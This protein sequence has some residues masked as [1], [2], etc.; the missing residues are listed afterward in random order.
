MSHSPPPRPQASAKRL[1]GRPWART[2]APASLPWRRRTAPPGSRTSI[3]GRGTDWWRRGS[4]CR[5]PGGRF[6]RPGGRRDSWSGS[7]PA[8]RTRGARAASV[9]VTCGAP[10][11]VNLSRSGDPENGQ[12]VAEAVHEVALVRLRH[13][14]GAVGHDREC[15]RRGADL[16]GVEELHLLT[17]LLRR[18]RPFEQLMRAPG[19]PRRW[20][21]LLPGVRHLEDQLEQLAA[22]AAR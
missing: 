4:G 15:R 16:G 9:A 17:R 20:H 2:P 8:G 10:R 22:P 18:R 21:A 5:A 12:A 1:G 19:S 14:V 13:V 6:P 3:P 11:R 7:R